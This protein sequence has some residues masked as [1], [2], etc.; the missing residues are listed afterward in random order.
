MSLVDDLKK[1][2]ESALN[3]EP[4][5]QEKAEEALVGPKEDKA[6]RAF[7]ESSAPT[8]AE[9]PQENQ[10][11]QVELAPEVVGNPT[12]MKAPTETPL[13]VEQPLEIERVERNPFKE[14]FYQTTAQTLFKEDAPE[15][16]EEREQRKKRERAR[17][18][19]FS[20]A[21]IGAHIANMWG[22]QGGASSID[23][24]S[25]T[26]A[27]RKRMD[28]AKENRD[29]N[30]D[31]YRRSMFQAMAMDQQ[32]NVAEQAR[33]EQLAQYK[34]RRSDELKRNEEKLEQQRW[35]NAF[36][37]NQ[38]EQE[39]YFKENS[40]TLAQSKDERE[41][42]L[43]KARLGLIQAQT[44]NLKTP[45]GKNLTYNPQP[46][47]FEYQ[48]DYNGVPVKK[49]MIV[50]VPKELKSSFISIVYNEMVAVAQKLDDERTTALAAGEQTNI[51]MI[52]KTF[53]GFAEG[54]LETTSSKME[55]AM[56]SH[57]AS[58]GMQAFISAQASRISRS[59]IKHLYKPDRTE[60]LGAHNIQTPVQPVPPTVGLGSIGLSPEEAQW[61][62]D[63]DIPIVE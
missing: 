53:E 54:S 16:E 32:A 18:I 8:V 59:Y 43:Q 51:D 52:R 45:D 19:L 10:A 26:D 49:T 21:D 3:P 55:T 58:L 29:R 62:S 35:E 36:K 20:F 39:L 11:Q 27:H 5:F 37:E 23:V 63:N 4:Y 6:M 7:N 46:Y 33:L 17:N 47:A 12:V 34:E 30:K 38:L 14:G 40:L 25:M 1:K 42:Q 24:S 48:S 56:L 15:T 31:A 13:E 2:W 41:E 9:V 60:A 22:T 28:I 50:E 61:F 44:Y 57:A